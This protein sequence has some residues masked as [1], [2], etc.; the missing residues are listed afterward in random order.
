MSRNADPQRGTSTPK[1]LDIPSPTVSFPA[2]RVSVTLGLPGGFVNAV[3][4]P[5]KGVLSSGA[6]PLATCYRA[7]NCEH[8]EPG[9]TCDD[10][11]DGFLCGEDELSPRLRGRAMTP[12]STCDAGPQSH[13]A[14]H[15]SPSPLAASD[16][17]KFIRVPIP[18][19]TRRTAMTTK[20]E[21]SLPTADYAKSRFT[22][23]KQALTYTLMQAS[24][25]M[26]FFDI[27]D[28]CRSSH[29]EQD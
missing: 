14:P 11:P 27:D 25:C 1:A 5:Q 16:P 8:E 3:G 26:P 10:G 4:I 15:G 28:F 7:N 9:R 29:D 23:C 24:A 12:M 6:V 2:R 20:S 19:P 13:H 21:K 17:A 18:L 22:A